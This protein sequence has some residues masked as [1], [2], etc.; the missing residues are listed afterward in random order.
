MGAGPRGSGESITY[1]GVQFGDHNAQYN[2]FGPVVRTLFIGPVERLQDVCFD[3]APL[4]RDLDLAR[5]VGRDWLIERIDGFIAANPRGYVLVQAEAGVGKSTLAAHLVWTR[6]WLQ[7][8]TRLPGG[9][10]GEAARKSLAAQLIAQWRLAEQWAPDGIIP[11]TSGRPEWFSRLLHAAAHERNRSAPGEP[12]VL[13]IDGLDEIDDGP[14]VDGSGPPLGLLGSLPDGVFVIATSRFGFGR[15]L[16]GMRRPIAWLEIEVDGRQNLEDIRRFISVVTHPDSGDE[17]L[18]R[19]VRDGGTELEWFR[20]AVAQSCAGVWIY[21]QYVLDEIRDGVRGPRSVAELPSDLAGYYAQQIERWRGAPHDEAAQRQW[22]QV[23]RPLL[24]VLAAARAP[25]TAEQLSL[26][27]RMPS[28]EAVRVFA[29]E[30]IRPFLYRQDDASGEPRYAIRHQSLRDL[31]EGRLQA[32]RPDVAGMARALTTQVHAAHRA[33]TEALTPPGTE[34]ER[35]WSDAGAYARTHLAAHAAAAGV[36]DALV[37]DPGFLL[38]AGPDA[39]LAQRGGLH[40]ADGRHA[41]AAFELSLHDWTPNARSQNLTRLAANAARLGSDALVAACRRRADGEWPIRWASWGGR[42]HLKLV[43]GDD[44]VDSVV[45]GLVGPRPVVVSGCFDGTVRIWDAVS[46]ARLGALP[47]LDS[48]VMS[49]ALGRV[50]DHDLIVAGDEEGW[51]RVWDATDRKPVGV[52]LAGHDGAVNAVAFGRVG[53]RDVI[54]SGGGDGAVRVWEAATREPLGATLAAHDGAVNAVAFGRVGDRD[55]IV[56][57]AEDST[58]RI[59]DPVTH[60]QIGSPFIGHDGA[61]RAVVIG[62]VA[63]RDVIVTNAYDLRRSAGSASAG[64]VRVWDAAT[65][66]CTD[67]SLDYHASVATLAVGRIDGRDVIVTGAFDLTVRIWDAATGAQLGAPLAGHTSSVVAVAIDRV[68]GRD[69]IVS[70]SGD[71]TVRIWDATLASPATAS[72]AGHRLPVESVAI[73]RA[74]ERDVVVSGARDGTVLIWDAATGA[75]ISALAGHFAPVHA[76]ALGRAADREVIITSSEDGTACVWDA[77]TGDVVHV[78]GG[79]DSGVRAL[80]T[81]RA[82]DRD[83]IVSGGLH[84]DEKVRVWDAV[85]GDL[86][87]TLRVRAG[88]RTVALGRA[89]NRDV[90]VCGSGEGHIHVWDAATGE[91]TVPAMPAFTAPRLIG[92]A[93]DVLCVAIGR[94]GDRDVIASGTWESTVRLWDA[95][96]GQPLGEPLVGHGKGVCSVAFGRFGDRDLVISGSVDSTVRLWDALTGAPVGT[97]LTGH[98]GTVYAVATGRVGDCD[99]VVSGSEDTTVIAYEHSPRREWPR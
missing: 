87:R 48:A 16:H 79:H 76:V 29:E 62:R 78:L 70:G 3:P 2:Y 42:Q 92:H 22:A 20:R 49:V 96:T 39:V 73:G 25:L 23:I 37:C 36:L 41:L 47:A 63:G 90:I 98:H 18:L 81:G 77:A 55:V 74:G 30:T 93:R 85:R 65:G 32:G 50:A 99:L 27:A 43:G 84:G 4:E 66:R 14:E 1:Q 52:P 56:S 71:G 26:F 88:S 35:D 44:V 5:F 86:I 13:V 46:G 58:V 21:L 61:V 33:I 53:D 9:R 82:G 80:A 97:A 19:A 12:I 10:S 83:V 69:V 57:G 6:P 89:G 45:L 38:V 34:D 60:R 64:G 68:Q 59:W 24:G 91:L 7:H 67:I 51:I 75:Q 11:P 15:A 28:T 94:N 17:R 72:A 40:T 8:F 54:V 95:V 31:M